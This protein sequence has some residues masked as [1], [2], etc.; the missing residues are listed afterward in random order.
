[1]QLLPN[2]V[3]APCTR[4]SRVT[5]IGSLD[6]N[7]KGIRGDSYEGSGLSFSLH[8]DAWEAIAKL[9][10]QT[11]WESD[12]R[13]MHVLDG[14]AMVHAHGEALAQWGVEEGLV[15]PGTAWLVSWFDD[16]LNDTMSMWCNSFEQAQDEQRDE[17]DL[18]EQRDTYL[19][20]QALRDAMRHQQ[21]A[22]VV[23][24]SV[25][26]DLAAIWAQRQGLHGVWWKDSLAP[27]RLSAPRGVLFPEH[28][29][30]GKWAPARQPQP[31]KRLGC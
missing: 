22:G 5:H 27:D 13:D 23:D 17:D 11:W 6:A 1:M 4:L 28:V 19:P 29:D 26:D 18:I 7:Q 15:V 16:E 21:A 30:P 24:C 20:T 14:H 12:L 31:R 25:L 2:F 3:D 8:P 9:G 10:G